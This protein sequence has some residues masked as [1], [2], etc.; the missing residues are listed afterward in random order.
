MIGAWLCTVMLAQPPIDA[1]KPAPSAAVLKLPAQMQAQPGQPFAVI[2]ETNLKWQR[3][4]IPPGLT[5]VPP[6]LTSCGEK[7]FVGY[8]PAGVYEFRVEGTVNDQYAEA[9]C[10]V[11]VG[12]PAPPGPRPDPR[13]EPPAP[14]TDPFVAELQKLYD[15]D[16]SPKK[17][18]YRDT[19]ASIYSTAAAGA[20]RDP[21][22]ATTGQLFAKLRTVSQLMLPDDAL[23]PLRER[24]AA[25]CRQHFSADV[26]LSDEV[27]AKACHCFEKIAAAL[28]AIK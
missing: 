16:K 28:N 9:T 27:R 23:R 14:P 13:P 19:L 7:G 20:M 22:V 10:V 8:G 6:E 17:A 25:E 18:D 2:A 1:A 12:Q 4:K 24:L 15:A 5:R 26:P 21:E 11:F 3:W